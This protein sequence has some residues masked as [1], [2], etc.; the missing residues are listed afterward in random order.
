MKFLEHHKS[1]ST[2]WKQRDFALMVCI[3]LLVS[4]ITLSVLL[5]TKEEQWVLIPQFDIQERMPVS[6]GKLSDAYLERWATSVV[7]DL[8]TANP[9]SVDMKV[10]RFLEVASTAFGDME[11]PLKKDAAIQKRE[12][13]STAFYPKEVFLKGN[14]ISLSGAFYVYFGRDK[15]PIITN[16]TYELGFVRR[17]H[18]VVLV[19]SLEE[20]K[21]EE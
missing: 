7:Q 6:K 9:D 15:K 16:K 4:N 11:G 14:T 17:G 21:N 10:H 13:F 3:G 8:L 1:L 20:L 5:F 12:G 2:A 19:T 18:G